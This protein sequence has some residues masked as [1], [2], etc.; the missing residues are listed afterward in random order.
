[1]KKYISTVR[2]IVC[3]FTVLLSGCAGSRQTEKAGSSASEQNPSVDGSSSD[4]GA[5]EEP[6]SA[7]N[8]TAGQNDREEERLKM[9]SRGY[10]F[11]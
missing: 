2:I 3:A 7:E 6:R 9:K 11:P 10:P 4:A 8:D 1:M 5:I